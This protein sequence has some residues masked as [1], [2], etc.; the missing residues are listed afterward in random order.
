MVGKLS[1]ILGL[2]QGLFP[3]RPTKNLH[4]HAP[5]ILV[6]GHGQHTHHLANS[7]RASLF[8]AMI[9]SIIASISF[10]CLLRM[11]HRDGYCENK[12]LVK[13]TFRYR[14]TGLSK[15]GLQ[16]VVLGRKKHYSKVSYYIAVVMSEPLRQCL[17][18][19]TRQI[20]TACNRALKSFSL[21][22]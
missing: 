1:S 18:H 8:S 15:I 2:L 6:E 11:H 17:S 12:F 22:Q 9:S 10:R 14:K 20:L 5:W 13:P 4:H 21:L 3:R 7:T 16:S 19:R